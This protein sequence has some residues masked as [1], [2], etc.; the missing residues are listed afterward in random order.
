MSEFAN[1]SFDHL[2]PA[3][4]GLGAALLR[5]R[6][7]AIACLVALA[8]GGWVVL[9]LLA[10]QAAAG[11]TLIEALG[12]LC[13]PGAGG[14]LAA[15]AFIPVF[16]M[17]SAMTLAMMLPTAAPMI[18]TYADIA[19]TAAARRQ[20][21]VS[22]FA[23]VAGYCAVWIGFAVLATLAQIYVV[24]PLV[25]AD[26]P[27]AA[28][29][30]LAAALFLAAGAYQFSALKL[31]CLSACRQPFPFFFA[32]W[33]TGMA[34]VFGLGL[35]QGLHCLGCCWAMML[36]MF[37]GGAMN[38]LW[39]AVLGAVMLIEKLT[40]AP[41]FSRAVGIVLLLAGS[42]FALTAISGLSR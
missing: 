23:L 6:L 37:A 20:N 34:G 36:L 39:M 27:A 21:V 11:G 33:K 12:A 29:A 26:A 10:G 25:P 19:E 16:A 35:R 32:N 3:A 4:A 1:R 40:A 7:I 24:A 17:W 5:P 38:A 8:G 13:R 18:L 22:P 42:A 15:S 9:G 2:S 28:S 14:G 41:H 30:A 31:A